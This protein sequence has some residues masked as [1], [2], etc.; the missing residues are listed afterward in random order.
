MAGLVQGLIQMGLSYPLDTIKT[1]IQVHQQK[2][3]P[4]V[5]RI[6]QQH[7]L[8]GFYSGALLPMALKSVKRGVQMPLYEALVARDYNTYIAGAAAG[9]IGIPF[10]CPLHTIMVNRQTHAFK[11]SLACVQ[12]LRVQRLYQAT[13]PQLGRDVVMGSMYLGTYGWLRSLPG[14]PL[15]PILLGGLSGSVAWLVCYPI[16]TLVAR[17]QS[18]TKTTLQ[19]FSR[20]IS[21]A[22]V[23]VWL[24]NGTAM[25]VYERLRPD[26]WK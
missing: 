10:A 16:D 17:Q 14:D 11:H 21:V 26:A 19:S 13:L 5:K 6:Y 18:T 9:A 15:H 23:R 25:W 2:A 22:F 8:G 3:W 7:G 1:N 24:S 12:S 4:T 20:G